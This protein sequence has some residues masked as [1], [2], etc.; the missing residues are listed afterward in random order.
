MQ[1]PQQRIFLYLVAFSDKTNLKN[2]KVVNI[3]D[4]LYSVRWCLFYRTFNCVLV[5]L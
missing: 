5:I 4:S 3:F 1:W 2:E